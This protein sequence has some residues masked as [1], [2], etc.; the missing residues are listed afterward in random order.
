MQILEVGKPYPEGLKRIPEG[1]IFNSDQ[2][3]GLLRIVFESPLESEI[4]E[5]TQGKIKLGLLEEAGIIF[6]FIKFGELPWMDAPYNVDLSKFYDLEDLTD[7]KKGYA[8]QIVLIDGIT[9]IVQALKLIELPHEMS[10]HFN[11]VVEKQ[12]ATPIKDYDNVLNRI[13]SRYDT[14]TLVKEVEI[15]LV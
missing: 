3:G 10:K 1:M 2:S 7:K 15:Y 13:Y 14:D 5:I 6:F 12:R 11:E 9:G 8:V 4:K